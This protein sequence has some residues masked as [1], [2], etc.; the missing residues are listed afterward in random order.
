MRT[1]LATAPASDGVARWKYRTQPDTW[2]CHGG[3]EYVDRGDEE[4]DGE[5][6]AY[7]VGPGYYS[8]VVAAYNDQGHSIFAIAEPG[9]WDSRGPRLLTSGGA[10]RLEER[11]EPVEILVGQRGERARVVGRGR[12]TS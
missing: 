5:G 4:R 7:A 3:Y 2:A 9:W 6:G 12:R 11:G 1:L 8:V 10:D